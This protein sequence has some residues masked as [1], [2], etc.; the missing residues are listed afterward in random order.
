[1]VTSS[2]PKFPGD[3]TAP[4]IESIARAVAARGHHGGR[5]AAAPP[6]AAPARRRARALLPLPLRA[7]RG[8]E[9]LGLRAEP[10]SR[11][12]RAR[13]ACTCW[14]RWWRWPCARRVSRPA[15]RRALRRRARAL[16]GAQRGDGRRTWCAR[17]GAPLVVSL[18]GSDVFLA[19]RLLPRA[20]CWPGAPCA[21]RGRRHRLQRRPATGARS[22]WARPP[23]A[24]ASCPTASTCAPSRREQARADVR[25][26]LGVAEDAF[27]VLALGRLVEKKG[28]ALP[29]GGGGAHGRRARGDRGRGRPARR[30]RG[31]QPRR[32]AR[33]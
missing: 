11:R 27:L 24:R 9:P 20:R 32:Q 7:A 26:R 31:A 12:A 8:V 5:G 21:D 13:R 15:D 14:R 18:H 30:A 28:F 33:R 1:M 17:N 22:A 2:Y 16:G 25:A 23:R 29:G 10:G 3:V 6:G 19:E 4:F